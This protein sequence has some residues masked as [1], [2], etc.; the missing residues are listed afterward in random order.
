MEPKI[1]LSKER[2]SILDLKGLNVCIQEEKIIVEMYGTQCLNDTVVLF[3]KW[4]TW[5]MDCIWNTISRLCAC[6]L[7]IHEDDFNLGGDVSSEEN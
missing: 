1:I 5:G 4:W 6:L 2:S 7:R 3:V